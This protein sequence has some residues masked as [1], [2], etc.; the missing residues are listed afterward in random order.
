[1]ELDARELAEAVHLLSAEFPDADRAQLESVLRECG[2]D[3]SAARRRLYEL[4]E[5]QQPSR[6][7]TRSSTAEVCVGV[8]ETAVGEG[9]AA[10]AQQFTSPRR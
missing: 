8:A 6:G 5:A 3:I 2:C 4:Q 7:P 9:G 1:M 10:P